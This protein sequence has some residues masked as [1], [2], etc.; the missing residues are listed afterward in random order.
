M[1]S[2]SAAQYKKEK[3]VIE[4]K[5]QK[6]RQVVPTIKTNEIILALHN[7]DLDVER[8]IQAFL[9][10]GSGALGDWENTAKSKKSKKKNTATKTNSTTSSTVDSTTG[11]LK[12]N[13]K[14]T[15]SNNG[16][17]NGYT[18]GV[19]STVVSAS[20]SAVKPKQAPK[21]TTTTNL[22]NID[23][24]NSD[25]KSKVLSAELNAL[26]RHQT[27]LNKVQKQFDSEISNAETSIAQCFKEIRQ[28]SAERERQLLAALS[29]VREEGTHYISARHSELRQ[30]QSST[31]NST[32]DS[33]VAELKRF[34]ANKQHDLELGHVTRFVYDNSQIINSIARFGEVVSI[35]G[36]IVLTPIMHS[37]PSQSN[38][39]KH[40]TSHSSLVSSVGEDSGLGQI[41]PVANEKN[42]AVHVE[43]SGIKM[44]SNAISVDQLAEIQRQLAEQLKAQGIDPSVLAGACGTAPPPRRRQQQYQNGNNKKQQ[45][46]N[47]KNNKPSIELSILN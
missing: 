16:Y 36:A 41:S 14:S 3:K 35:N 5:V 31:Q 45:N 24:L 33:V 26:N 6:V 8:T 10:E 47:K 15:S 37:H 43:G 2:T 11:I 28:I 21:I 12:Q 34:L 32:E 40:A 42:T 19:T 46:G 30:L 13:G 23:R 20:S 27:D 9:E 38:E 1:S 4:E 29:R 7:Y 17:K 44:Q 22:D 25:E 18:N 39:I